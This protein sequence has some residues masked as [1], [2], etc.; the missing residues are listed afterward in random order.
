M[1]R[2]K[3][4]GDLQLKFHPLADMC[5][6]TEGAEFD[7]LVAD[8]KANGLREPIVLFE[9]KILDGRN[10]YRACP[11]A[12]AEPDFIEGDGGLPGTISIC[13]LTGSSWMG[14]AAE[15]VI[16]ANIHRRHLTAEQKR[17]IIAELLKADPSKSDRQIAKTVKASP[18]Y[19]GKVRAEKEATGDVSTVDTRTDTKGRAQP[20]K[21]KPAT[22]PA[23][24]IEKIGGIVESAHVAPPEVITKNILDNIEGRKAVAR[25]CK[26][27][28]RVAS[29]LDQASRAE[30][31]AAIATLITAW[32][33]VLSLIEV[34]P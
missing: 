24:T 2:K 11:A 21:K 8:I 15:Y 9:G 30:I 7:T 23:P 29:S 4:G 22:K 34:M 5:P 10:R 20:A 14:D 1:A 6:L 31:S 25:A 32:K 12:G 18:T 27:M 19:V 3:K 33:R 17:E 16:S 26:K 13:H 28:L